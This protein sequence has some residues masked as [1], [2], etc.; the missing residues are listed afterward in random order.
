MVPF[1]VFP[2]IYS[3]AHRIVGQPVEAN[4]LLH[5]RQ[6]CPS[7][8]EL[9]VD[10]S[11]FWDAEWLDQVIYPM[12]APTEAFAKRISSKGKLNFR[13]RSRTASRYMHHRELYQVDDP[14]EKN[15]VELVKFIRS[16]SI[17]PNTQLERRR[18]INKCKE[19]IKN[20]VETWKHNGMVLTIRG[21]TR[22]KTK[23]SS[24]FSN[25]WHSFVLLRLE[26]GRLA[27]LEDLPEYQRPATIDMDESDFNDVLA[28]DAYGTFADKVRIHA[29][30]VAHELMSVR[31]CSA[32][33]ANLALSGVQY[34]LTRSKFSLVLATSPT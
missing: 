25:L 18:L 14:N 3:S 19:C 11:G 24:I 27:E 22:D 8:G 4:C 20:S 9:N 28:V 1:S 21:P 7:Y 23:K 17:L 31:D 5:L 2:S 29:F 34:E 30:T 16:T 12:P 10:E 13:Q 15:F 32:M 26:G 6:I 33:R